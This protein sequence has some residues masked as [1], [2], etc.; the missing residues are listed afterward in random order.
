MEIQAVN[1]RQ[2]EGCGNTE[3]WKRI[4]QRVSSSI[5]KIV[6]DTKI[7]IMGSGNVGGALAQ[8]RVKAGHTV[9][10]GAKF[11][12]SEKNI[13]LATKIGEDRFTNVSYAVK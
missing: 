4:L 2:I 11:P 3:H 6:L 9:L 5:S 1:E 7:A 10:V 8:Q 13:T 12:I